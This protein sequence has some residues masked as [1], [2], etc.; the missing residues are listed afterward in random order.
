MEFIDLLSYIWEHRNTH[1]F[2]A[3]ISYGTPV[4]LAIRVAS[5]VYE[6]RI[7]QVASR[8]RS[9][10]QGSSALNEYRKVIRAHDAEVQAWVK[11]AGRRTQA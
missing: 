7:E 11:A 5:Y 1:A 4:L 6:W 9:A 10:N 3:L 8:K 2:M